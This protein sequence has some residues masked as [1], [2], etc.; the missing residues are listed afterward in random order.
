MLDSNLQSEISHNAEKLATATKSKASAGE[1]QATAEGDL[2]ETTRTKAADQDYSA[3]LKT[4]CE[5]AASEWGAR[6]ASAKEEMAAIDKASEILVGGVVA[7]VQSG[8]KLTK[9]SV[10]DDDCESDA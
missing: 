9:K 1:S 2:A 3:T 5:M 7:F 6:Q 4:E 8:A 10:D